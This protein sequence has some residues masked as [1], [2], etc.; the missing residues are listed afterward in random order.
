[1]GEF[2][3]NKSLSTVINQSLHAL[4][5]LAKF[6]EACGV[7]IALDDTPHNRFVMIADKTTSAK[8]A[9]PAMHTR[10]SPQKTA[11]PQNAP[12]AHDDGLPSAHS[13]R[14]ALVKARVAQT[15]SLAELHALMTALP[16]CAL[17]KTASHCLTG[18]GPV[19]AP[20]MVVCLHP[21][22]EEDRSGQPF[23]GPEADLLAA[24]LRAIE[25]DLAT[26]FAT[27]LI[28]WRPPGRREPS[29]QEVELCLPFLRREIALVNPRIVLALGET[30]TATLLDSQLQS[31]KPVN[32]RARQGKEFALEAMM[33]DNPEDKSPQGFTLYAPDRLIAQPLL[34]REAWQGLLALKSLLANG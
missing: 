30:A 5:A 20:V 32:F 22:T 21:E 8:A 4:A 24:M 26:C 1:M 16:F 11:R 27:Y 17:S 28:P 23:V 13:E 31:G 9:Q 25:I 2:D 34:K 19:G 15:V 14:L 10:P 6:Y 12:S 33:L 18:I 3:H 29:A 7:D